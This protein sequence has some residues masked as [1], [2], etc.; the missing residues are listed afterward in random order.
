LSDEEKKHIIGLQ[1]S[2][3]TEYCKTIENAESLTYP[4]L[5]AM[6]ECAW[7]LSEHKDYH[8]FYSRLIFNVK[9]LDQWGIEYSKLF[10]EHK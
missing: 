8:D 4:R 2:V 9:H 10:L 3:W 6:A 1:A 5:C 7:T